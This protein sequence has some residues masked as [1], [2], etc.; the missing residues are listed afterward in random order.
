MLR[1]ELAKKNQNFEKLVPTTQL[2]SFCAFI[3]F[4]YEMGGDINECD[5][6]K[7][8]LMNCV[9]VWKVGITQ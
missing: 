5:L 2:D 4:P 8:C 7:N 9:G 1:S 6:K 3:G